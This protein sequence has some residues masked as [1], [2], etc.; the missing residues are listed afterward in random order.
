MGGGESSQDPFDRAAQDAHDRA[1]ADTGSGF[2]AAEAATVIYAQKA[3]Y[4][5]GSDGA[6]PNT[7]TVGGNV[8]DAATTAIGVI[9]SNTDTSTK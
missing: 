8:F 2:R 6:I 9:R 7:G 4:D 1:L 5:S 3:M